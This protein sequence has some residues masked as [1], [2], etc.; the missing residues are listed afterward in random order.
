MILMD[1]STAFNNYCGSYNHT[2]KTMGEPLCIYLFEL[3]ERE[4]ER[5]KFS[6]ERH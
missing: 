3:T 4:R 1:Q 2:S 5:I 6:N